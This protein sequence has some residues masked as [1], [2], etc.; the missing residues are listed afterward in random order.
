M[1]QTNIRSLK[2]I[3]KDIKKHWQTPNHFASYWI[4]MLE[5]VD[6]LSDKVTYSLNTGKDCATKFLIH[7]QNWRGE[8]ARRIKNELKQMLKEK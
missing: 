5:T 8:E 3:A 2:E 1:Q 7:A 6:K 4:T